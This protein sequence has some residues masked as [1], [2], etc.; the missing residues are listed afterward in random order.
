MVAQR[1][2]KVVLLAVFVLLL[3]GCFP[4]GANRAP[5]AEFTAEPREGYDPLTVL[6]DADASYDPDG[7]LIT[8]AWEFGD[9]TSG[10]GRAASHTYAAGTYQVT[11]RVVDPEGLMGT[12][13]ETID[14]RPVP[15]GYRVIRYEW[16]Y[17]GR[18]HTWDLLLDEG[19]YETYHGRLRTSIGDLHDYAAYVNDPLDDPTLETL[20]EA[21]W[22]RAGRGFEPFVE[23]A[24]AFVQGAIDYRVDPPTS[25]WPLYPIETLF[26]KAGDCEDTTILFVSLL[27]ARGYRSKIAFVDTD[28]DGTP[29]HVL[30]LVSVPAAY[31]GEIRCSGQGLA[32][33]LWYSGDLFVIAETAVSGDPIPFGCDPWR[34]SADDVFTIWD[35]GP[36]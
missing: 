16:P 34:L 11:L 25:E 13:T 14:V 3:S 21:L 28:T 2:A 30:A 5:T 10:V 8:Y 26:E 23:C 15:A 4:P 7:D 19:L 18:I 31:L 35:I 36:P 24:L 27:K 1:T 9:G 17:E 29:D 6:F 22:N 33:V 32:T 20:A 12:T